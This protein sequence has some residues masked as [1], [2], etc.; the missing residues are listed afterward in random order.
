MDYC[1]AC[2]SHLT[3]ESGEDGTRFVCGGCGRDHY[4]N[5]VPVVAG[6]GCRDGR[7]LLI[8]RDVAPCRGQWALP[9][10]FIR[11]GEV[12]AATVERE[13]GE[14][15]GVTAVVS[16]LLGVYAEH[17]ERY[18]WILTLVYL[19]D[20][21]DEEPRGGDDAADAAFFSLSA[22]PPVAFPSHREALRSYL[23]ELG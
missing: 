18:P 9:S 11:I 2:G 22:M 13:F 16:R 3:A 4:E 21:G 5:P 6:I 7:V 12:P 1:P 23:E 8:K 10:G 20:I 14:E 19:L 15:T 17:G